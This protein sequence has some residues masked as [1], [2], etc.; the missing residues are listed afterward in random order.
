MATG[1]GPEWG[2][3]ETVN[4]RHHHHKYWILAGMA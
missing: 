2:F 1:L 4:F 3:M